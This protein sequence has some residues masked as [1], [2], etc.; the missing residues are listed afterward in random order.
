MSDQIT[1]YMALIEEDKLLIKSLNSGEVK[2]EFDL[3]A[4]AV[5]Q[6]YEKKVSK[7]P[8]QSNEVENE[9]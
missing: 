3:Q 9:A 1:K 2:L 4:I 6:G 5:F 7:I 8:L